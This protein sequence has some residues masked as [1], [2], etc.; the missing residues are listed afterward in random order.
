MNS[1]SDDLRAWRKEKR[2]ALISQ[3]EA[4]DLQTRET[5]RKSMDQ[6]LERGFP[7]LNRGVLALCWPYRGEY[8]ARHL[9][10]RLR[11]AGAT[12]ALPVIVAPRAPLVFREWHPG[13][14][15]G[16][17]P[18]GIPFPMDSPQVQPDVVLLPMVGFDSRGYRLGYGGG[19][20]DRTMAAIS[21]R[22]LLIGV[23][24]ELAKLDSVFPQPH[25]VPVDYVVTEQGIYR[26]DEGALVFLGA[27]PAGE[28]STLSSP[29]CF[30]SEFTPS[31]SGNKDPQEP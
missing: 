11:R 4:V 12:T 18:L 26:R 24:H 16:D 6:Y 27:S 31:D 10:A 23:A 21:R 22:P 5:W 14:R 15:L 13:V 29:A 2:H 9:A 19:Y 20:F 8:D 25:D 3:R 1:F 28:P 17:G 7:G 30:A